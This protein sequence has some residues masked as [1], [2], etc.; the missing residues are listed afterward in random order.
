M[1]PTHDRTFAR[2]YAPFG[3][4]APQGRRAD[5]PCAPA[6][7][8]ESTG[9]NLPP[10]PR[11]SCAAWPRLTLPWPAALRLRT[12]EFSGKPRQQL[13]LRDKMEHTPVRRIAQ[14]SEMDLPASGCH[15]P[16][17]VSMPGPCAP[18]G[19]E[20]STVGR[21]ADCCGALHLPVP[22]RP[23]ARSSKAFAGEAWTDDLTGGDGCLTLAVKDDGVCLDALM[24]GR[25]WGYV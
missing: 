19:S 11:D 21:G 22:C 23:R 3:S 2:S 4:A 7:K 24:T 13:L 8:V 15:P 16:L 20:E 5:A 12:R 10:P 14:S 6:S 17:L 25:R 18:A 9:L 1:L